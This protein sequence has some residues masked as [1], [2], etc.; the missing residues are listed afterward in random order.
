MMD[1]TLSKATEARVAAKAYEA[2]A[3]KVYTDLLFNTIGSMRPLAEAGSYP[4]GKV[5]Y[6]TPR[7][8]G[9]TQ[10]E[11]KRL[12]QA[13]IERATTRLPKD[14]VDNIN[15]RYGAS[16]I[17]IKFKSAD[18]SGWWKNWSGEIYVGRT[19]ANPG[20]EV[21]G[22][23][24]LDSTLLHEMTHSAQQTNEEAHQLELAYMREVGTGRITVLPGYT[25]GTTGDVDNFTRVYSGRAY[26]GDFREVLTTGMEG[27]ITPSVVSGETPHEESFGGNTSFQNFMTGT[28]LL[29]SRSSVSQ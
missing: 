6:G 13:A 11:G 7:D 10:A 1:E 23:A 9:M 20:P 22:R 29:A 5:Q 3:S 21:A 2:E 17:S 24:S 16:G 4:L 27:M 28:L 18:G 25:R 15:K 26:N 19:A 8:S 12:T 14:W